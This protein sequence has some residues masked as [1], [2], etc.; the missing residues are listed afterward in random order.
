[1]SMIWISVAALA[2]IALVAAALML[3]P[4]ALPPWWK[5]QIFGR[6]TT[7]LLSMIALALMFIAL[8]RAVTG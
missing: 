5:P 3:P 8:L 7:L 2:A 6:H 4:G 1:M